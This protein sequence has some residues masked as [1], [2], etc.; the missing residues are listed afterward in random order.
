MGPDKGDTLLKEIQDDEYLE[1]VSL[2]NRDDEGSNE[3]ASTCTP[4]R[5]FPRVMNF[6]SQMNLSGLKYAHLC[7]DTKEDRLFVFGVHTGYSGSTPLG[8]RPGLI[9]H[10]GLSHKDP[11]LAGS[12]DESQWAARV[13]AFNLKSIILLPPV[14]ATGSGSRDMVSELM[15]TTTNDE[16]GVSYIFTIEAG[17]GE[18]ME[19]RRFEWRQFKKGAQDGADKDGFKLLSFGSNSGD[20]GESSTSASTTAAEATQE[21]AGG[22]PLAMITWAKLGAKISHPLS[23]EF[24]DDTVPAL[25]GERWA[26]MVVITSLRLWALRMNGRGKKSTVAIAEKIRGKSAA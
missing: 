19:R 17:Q 16:G 24:A 14:E 2:P 8:T 5:P 25:F 6:Y 18:K 11:I 22:R 26:L 15:T 23:L 3:P 13:Y 4:Y 7:G 9:L 1:Q 10:N 20:L 12:C 21:S